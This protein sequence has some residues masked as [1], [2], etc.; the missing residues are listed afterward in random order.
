MSEG[1][2]RFI[3]K[4]ITIQSDGEWDYELIERDVALFVRILEEE[5]LDIIVKEPPHE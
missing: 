1:I 4:F 2:E 5:G 3:R